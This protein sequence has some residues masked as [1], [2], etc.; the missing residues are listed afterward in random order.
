MR[1]L[2]F[3]LVACAI[4]LCQGGVASA[5]TVPGDMSVVPGGN[6]PST[7]LQTGVGPLVEESQDPD[8]GLT[9][10]H[11]SKILVC[12]SAATFL[13]AVFSFLTRKFDWQKL[14]E[15]QTCR[16]CL[17]IHSNCGSTATLCDWLTLIA[18]TNLA[19][20]PFAAA[21][22]EEAITGTRIG[23]AV[24]MGLAGVILLLGSGWM[25]RSTLKI[26]PNH[27][28]QGQDILAAVLTGTRLFG[29]FLSVTLLSGGFAT[30]NVSSQINGLLGTEIGQRL[31]EEVGILPF[32]D[33]AVIL[34]VTTLLSAILRWPIPWLLGSRPLV[35]L[36]N[37]SVSPL[38]NIVP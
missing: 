7:D 28:N 9:N 5:Q 1:R 6:A 12:I 32:R 37:R 24:L 26:L 17:T 30:A 23:L 29:A 8:E 2:W 21:L 36:S 35:L 22:H 11:R 3:L 33:T 38:R 4:L 31:Q 10:Q 27:S 15:D 25:I 20:L 19:M 13:I 16:R 14:A 34:L 18:F